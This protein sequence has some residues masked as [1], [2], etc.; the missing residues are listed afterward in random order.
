MYYNNYNNTISH[1]IKE[2]HKLKLVST[3][4]DKNVIFLLTSVNLDRKSLSY[5][6]NDR[7]VG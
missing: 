2:I 3:R 7:K 1:Q 4:K 5:N 6:L